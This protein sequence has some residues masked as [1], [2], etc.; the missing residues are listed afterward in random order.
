MTFQSN[1]EKKLCFQPF[2]YM[3]KV[4]SM[5]SETLF[6]ISLPRD[7]KTSAKSKTENQQKT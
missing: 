6:Y 4:Y 7:Y 1:M 5:L 3:N 2:F